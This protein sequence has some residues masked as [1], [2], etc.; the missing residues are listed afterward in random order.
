MGSQTPNSCFSIL[1]KNHHMTT[2]NLFWVCISRFIQKFHYNPHKTTV[3]YE[4]PNKTN[5][6]NP[7]QISSRK[8]YVWSGY[9]SP[10]CGQNSKYVTCIVHDNKYYWIYVSFWSCMSII[11]KSLMC[12]HSSFYKNNIRKLYSNAIIKPDFSIRYKFIWVVPTSKLW[13]DSTK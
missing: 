11:S 13:I 1:T 3:S 6:K 8:L 5:K 9:S 10:D 4:F 12:T 7:K 2:L